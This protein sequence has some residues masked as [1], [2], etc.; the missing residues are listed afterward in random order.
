MRIHPAFDRQY[1]QYDCAIP[2]SLVL[3]FFLFS[4]STIAESEN[5]DDNTWSPFARI[6]ADRGRCVKLL[7]SL[8]R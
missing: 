3:S 1:G 6:E 5:G 8:I 4:P 2:V 7:G